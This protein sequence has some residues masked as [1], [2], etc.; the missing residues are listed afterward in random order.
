MK[1]KYNA[2]HVRKYTDSN[3]E[4]KKAYTNIGVVLERDDGSLVLKLLDSWVN[5]Y[6]PRIGEKE[7]RE[8]K[9]AVAK[10][11]AYVQDDLNDDIPF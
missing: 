4:E 7:F 1:R 5:F 11:N 9:H 6:E 2:V 10:G 8:V 3:G